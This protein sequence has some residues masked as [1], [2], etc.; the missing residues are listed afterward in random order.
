[1]AET[2]RIVKMRFIRA[3]TFAWGAFVAGKPSFV[4][5]SDTV[6]PVT[7]RGAARS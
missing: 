6:T 4:H 1:M 7:A 3:P 2:M 5:P